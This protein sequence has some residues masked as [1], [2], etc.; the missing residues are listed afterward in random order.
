MSLAFVYDEIFLEHDT[1]DHPENKER[2]KAINQGIID[3]NLNLD[4]IA[5]TAATVEEISRVHSTT[6]VQFVEQRVKHGQHNLGPDTIVSDKSYLAATKAAGSG[7]TAAEQ[8]INGPHTTAFCSVRPP[9]HHAVKNSAMGFCLFNNIAVTAR[10]L[11][12]VHNIEKIFIL[13]WDVHHGNGTEEAFYEES[14]IYVLSLHQYP[15]FPGTGKKDDIGKGAGLHYN[16]N[17]PM[18]LGSLDGDYFEAFENVVLPTIKKFAP[19]IILISCGFDAHRMDLYSSMNL[20]SRAF[21][22]LTKQVMSV[23]DSAE[24]RVISF[25]EG[26]YDLNALSES[27]VYHLKALNV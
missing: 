21:G 17:I 19:Q 11:Q 5:P 13:D 25:L 9:G 14:G 20:S 1:N 15:H 7:I 6:Y 10:H 26:G 3:S 18:R 23:A 22:T 4:H 24:G 27:V 8:I 2:L 12:A 16:K